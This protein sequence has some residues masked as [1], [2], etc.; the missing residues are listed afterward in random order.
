MEDCYCTKSYLNIMKSNK[1]VCENFFFPY[2]W[3][4]FIPMSESQSRPVTV[5]LKGHMTNLTAPQ[6]LIAQV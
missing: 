2:S 5:R 1:H 4:G 6:L 3:A